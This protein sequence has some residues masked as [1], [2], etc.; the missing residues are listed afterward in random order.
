MLSWLL[1]FRH[2]HGLSR[3]FRFLKRP[4]EPTWLRC[5]EYAKE[6]GFAFKAASHGILVKLHYLLDEE[7]CLDLVSQLEA[8]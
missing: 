7:V 5:H 2:Q 8:I 4:L 3:Q 1:D 6:A